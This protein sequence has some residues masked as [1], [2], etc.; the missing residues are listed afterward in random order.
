MIQRFPSI[1]NPLQ[2]RWVQNV[3][4]GTGWRKTHRGSYRRSPH[5]PSG[6]SLACVERLRHKA[7]GVA[8]THQRVSPFG[9]L[10]RAFALAP[11]FSTGWAEGGN[12]PPRLNAWKNIPCKGQIDFPWIGFS[13]IRVE[14]H[15]ICFFPLP[16]G[17]GRG[18]FFKGGRVR[19]AFAG[20][21]K[22]EAAGGARP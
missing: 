3:A 9:N 20:G 2:R 4:L 7:L 15:F 21:G 14:R 19:Y 5:S 17:M 16:K 6:C 18:G 10:T 13:E 11:P 1:D 22:P 12:A 8:Q